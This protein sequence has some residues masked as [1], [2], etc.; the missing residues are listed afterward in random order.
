MH[1]TRGRGL[2]KLLIQRQGKVIKEA[3]RLGKAYTL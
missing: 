1:T 3:E 2:R